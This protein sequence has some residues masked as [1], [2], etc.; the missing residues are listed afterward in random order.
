MCLSPAVTS[1]EPY[2]LYLCYFSY[3]NYVFQIFLWNWLTVCWVFFKIVVFGLLYKKENIILVL[4][5]TSSQKFSKWELIH[6][7]Y[8]QLLFCC[9]LVVKSCPSFCDSMTVACQDPLSMEFFKQEYWSG[10]TFPSP[11][12]LPDPGME[13]KT[14]VSPAL[15][16]RFFT[17]V[18]PGKTNEQL[19]V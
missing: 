18:S 15:A 10:W 19:D 12:D 14:L 1:V 5:F 16:G 17:T 2:S 9:Y 4:S 13:P 8:E 3:L 6:R 7:V 11:G